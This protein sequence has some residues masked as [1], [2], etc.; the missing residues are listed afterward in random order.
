MRYTLNLALIVS[1]TFVGCTLRNNKNDKLTNSQNK[2]IIRIHKK[3]SFL[4][5]CSYPT[6]SLRLTDKFQLGSNVGE[7]DTLLSFRADPNLKYADN[8][9]IIVDYLSTD[10]KLTIKQKTGSVNGILTFSADKKYQQIFNIKAN[11][12]FDIE[13]TEENLKEA[14][15]SLNSLFPKLTGKID[16]DI[17]KQ[18]TLE[19]RYYIEIFKLSKPQDNSWWIL[20][21]EVRLK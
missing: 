20:R 11:W 16:F 14:L 15:V 17:N 9:D 10:T 12:L 13:N 6:L 1:F 3:E 2:R 18:Y 21:Y 4:K 5:S 7:L 19:N 8:M